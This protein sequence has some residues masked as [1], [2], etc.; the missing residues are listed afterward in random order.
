MN[1]DLTACY[2]DRE[3]RAHVQAVA[4]DPRGKY[5]GMCLMCREARAR[6]ITA[7]ASP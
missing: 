3:L 2:T 5:E 6:G 1:A 7:E 4:D